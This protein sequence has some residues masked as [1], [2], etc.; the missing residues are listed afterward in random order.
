MTKKSHARRIYIGTSGWSYAHW[1][2]PFYPEDIADAAMLGYYAERLSTVEINSSFY[3]LPQESALS[4]WKATV[5]SGFLFSAKAS[6][7]ITHMKKLKDPDRSLP[8][9]LS[10]IGLLGDRLGPLLFQLPPRWHCNPE[11]LGAFLKA[12][13]SDRRC[14]FEFRD[15]SWEDPAIY[16]LLARHGAALCIHDLDGRLSPRELTAGFVYVRLHGPDGPY[17]GSYDRR[18]LA[19]WAETFHDWADRGLEI[20]CYFD[21]DEAGYAALNALELQQL[22]VSG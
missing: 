16:D 22:A 3:H 11:R 12:L 6:R 2:G 9:F 17:R 19:G 5:P 14:A 4:H 13:G 10:R 7:Y 21:N 20:F 15:P 8:P 18:A 1:K